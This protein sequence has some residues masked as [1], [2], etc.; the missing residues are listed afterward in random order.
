[1]TGQVQ[2]TAAKDAL[3]QLQD[4]GLVVTKEAAEVRPELGDPRRCGDMKKLRGV[5]AAGDQGPKTSLQPQLA[6][7]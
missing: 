1:M 7:L 3:E 4:E 2:K 6:A 5:R